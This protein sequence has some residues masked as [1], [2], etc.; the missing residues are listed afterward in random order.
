MMKAVAKWVL[1]LWSLLCLIGVVTGVAKVGQTMADMKDRDQGMAGVGLGCGMVMWV[2]IWAAIA[3][4][5][6]VIYLVAGKREPIAVN[7]VRDQ[8]VR[9]SA[10]L[11]NECGKYYEGAPR[12]CPNCGKTIGA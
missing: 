4:P 5:S 6:L 3:L 10:R 12:F 2:G 7:L 1:I 9:Q 11:C 8:S